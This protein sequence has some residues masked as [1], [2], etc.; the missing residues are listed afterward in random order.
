MTLKGIDDRG[1]AGCRQDDLTG[2]IH[3]EQR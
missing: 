1:D 3:S 2:P